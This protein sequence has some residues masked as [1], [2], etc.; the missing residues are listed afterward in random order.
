[1]T[2][3]VG[4]RLK[5]PPHPGSFVRTKIIAPLALSVT[6][7]AKALG[8]TRAALSAFLNE[9]SSLSPEMALRMEKAFGVRMDTLMRMQNS[10]DIVQARKREGEIAV[11]RFQPKTRDGE[12]G[13]TGAESGH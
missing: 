11:E 12:P 4:Y 5:E 7:A 2:D 6:D 1:M 10:Y 8:I 3:A 9:H 13:R